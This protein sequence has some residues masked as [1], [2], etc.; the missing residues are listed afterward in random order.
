MAK[1]KVFF[2]DLDGTLRETVSGVTFINDP[3]D[4]K[5]IAGASKALSY[6]K[7]KGFTCIGVTNQGGVA[8]GKKSFADALE[9]QQITLTLFPELD[10]IY[11]C[12]DFQGNSCWFVSRNNYH[13]VDSIHLKG[14]FR[15]PGDGMLQYSFSQFADVDLNETWMVGDRP[16]DLEC[17]KAAKVNFIWAPIMRDKFVPGMHEEQ[18][19]DIERQTLLK[20]LA[21]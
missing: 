4:Q 8:A 17:A 3:K 12:P 7:S 5:P 18:I 14:S 20:F 11:F 13:E 2:F 21:I 15:K 9:E 19:I 10:A 1:Q 6:Y 16:E